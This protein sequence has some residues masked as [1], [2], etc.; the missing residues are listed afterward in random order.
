[1][2]RGRDKTAL[3]ISP[4]GVREDLNPALIPEGYL[5]ASSNWL[6]RQGVG[7]PRSGYEQDGTTLTAADR[8]MGFGFRGSLS[9]AINLVAHTLTKAYNRTAGGTYS[10]ITGTW[11]PSATS[12]HVR[13]VAYPSGGTLWLLR[14][15]L[16]N[17]IDKWSGSGNFTDPTQTAPACRDLTVTNGRV[18]GFN[19]TTGGTNFPYRAQWTDLNDVDTWPAGN[20]AE[21]DETPDEGVATR[22]FGP[23]TAGLY[24]EDS[25][26]LAVAQ[27]AATPFQFQLVAH[28]PGPVS[29]AALISF[30]GKHYWLA[31]DAVI[32]AFDGSKVE[33]VG[34]AIVKTFRENFD[35][36]SRQQVH[37]FVLPL[38]EPELWYVFPS[39]GSAIKRAMSVNLTSGAMNPH[40]FADDISASSEWLAQPEIT[41]DGLSGTWDALGD[42]YAT[43]DAMA[44]EAHPTAVLGTTGGKVMQYGLATNDDGT[45]I[46]WSFTHP[47]VPAGGLGNR[48]Y[49]DGITSYWKK[50]STSLTVTVGVTVTD[51]LGDADS[52][53]TSTFDIATDSNHLSTFTSKIGQWVKVRHAGASAIADLEHRGAG[54]LGWKRNMA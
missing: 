4:G 1:M 39:S 35:W 52:E 23:L 45:A 21:L 5:L 34:R 51:S 13:M 6:T 44:S 17:A 25:V 26:W 20:I 30:R 33:P 53:S 46:A 31:K 49:L 36:E 7:R 18:L 27:A 11:T 48:L 38:A 16:A 54:I 29:P 9:T 50:M 32:Y 28:T 14:T 10:D 43:W 19:V 12:Q 8:I 24:K 41:W 3:V 40:L 42:T 47:N 37:G 2:P 15:N 22:A